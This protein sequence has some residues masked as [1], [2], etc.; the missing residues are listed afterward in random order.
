MCNFVE[1]GSGWCG[2]A[3]CSERDSDTSQRRASSS[4]PISF[5]AARSAAITLE[6]FEV[7]ESAFSDFGMSVKYE[8]AGAVEWRLEWMQV[9]GVATASS[10]A[11]AGLV[12]GDRILAIDGRSV[13]A[14]SR[15][16]MLEILFGRKKGESSR[17]LV[18]GNGQAL[19]HF[20]SLIAS[21]SSRVSA[22]ELYHGQKNSRPRRR[23]RHMGT[24]HARAYHAMADD[25][26]YR[27]AR[28]ARWRRR[29]RN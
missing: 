28:R 22:P 14:L 13:A 8:C 16:E 23:L 25:F 20:I 11:K 9:S 19:P 2:A 10:A 3:L 4:H 24:S 18:L 21:P 26:R 7:Q 27:R 29:D 15:G 6:A 1:A 5:A 12:I 17:L